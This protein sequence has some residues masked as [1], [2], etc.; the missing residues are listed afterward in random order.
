MTVV[1]I[2][3][4]QIINLRILAR[5]AQSLGDNV[6][7]L[8]FDDPQRALDSF[9]TEPPDLIVTDFVMPI[10]DG[11]AFI[12]RCRRHQATIDTPIIVVTAY[13]DRDFRYRALDTGASD[14]LLS[15]VD[16]REFCIRVRNLLS[17]RRHQLAERGRADALEGELE[18]ALHRHAEAMRRK[19]EQL[20]RVVNTVPA[21]ISATD[22][23]GTI[24]L[25]NS[26]HQAYG[27]AEAPASAGLTMSDLFGADYGL[28]HRKLDAEI[29]AGGEAPGAFEEQVEDAGGEPRVLLTTKA[30]LTGAN[31]AAEGVVTVS[32]D[33]TDRKQQEQAVAESEERFRS[34][35][36]GSV[37]G[38]LIERDG[39][40]LFANRTLARLFGHTGE[41]DILAMDRIDGLF[42]LDEHERIRQIRETTMAGDTHG[43]LKEFAG[44][45]KTGEPIWLQAQAQRVSWKGKNALQLTVADVTLR[46]A[47][48]LQLQKQANFDALT[49]LPN[50]LLMMDRLRGAILSAA[51]H[52]HRGAV[53]FIDLDHFK[54]INDTLGHAT[55]DALLKEAADRLTHCVR[56][57]DTVSRIGGD[58]FT[59]ILPNIDSAASAEPVVQKI[60]QTFSQPFLLSDLE[61]VVSA[62]IGITIFP[63]GGS[64]PE[65]LM[66]NADVAMYRSKERG[67]NTFE[68]FTESLSIRASE[69]IRMETS[70]RHALARNELSVRF[71]PIFDVRSKR[72]AGAEAQLHWH[73]PEMGPVPP[74][75]FM[76][77]AEETGLIVPIRAWSLDEACRQWSR[78][79]G[80]GL[81]LGRLVVNISAGHKRVGSLLENVKTILDGYA[82]DG[83]WLELEISERSLLRNGD[84]AA[85]NLYA[86]D[87]FGVQIAVDEF[88]AEAASVTQLRDITADEIRISGAFFSAALADN[89]HARIIQAIV[90]MAHSLGIRVVANGVDSE[91]HL[92]LARSSGCDFAQGL[93]LGS[94]LPAEAY[95]R[96]ASQQ[97]AFD[98]RAV[99]AESAAAGGLPRAP[100]HDAS[101]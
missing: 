60:L 34:L 5:F 19:E 25:L 16:G 64:D 45:K 94:P 13:E 70:L 92:M 6:K 38:I 99:A 46:K 71:Q 97:D 84:G 85:G 75:R 61:A 73:N 56:G 7:V 31:A 21:L 74:E 63:D 29:L 69:E 20:R 90:T 65:T 91:P 15:P 62:S 30:P 8:T 51:R 53:L 17:L 28:R 98:H 36:E 87:G 42:P 14:F 12:G 59:V 22:R 4:D 68:Y 1:Y 89:K 33:I 52:K 50:R 24:C 83:E 66:K 26:R 76:A 72:L 57:E 43:E 81:T 54:K 55:G 9:A 58:E 78:W 67:R 10:M 49:G 35:V 27:A 48:E 39:K 82:L 18:S 88:G 79:R 96:W 32:L 95:A 80:A 77:C 23:N 37:L 47:Y 101:C 11:E 93:Y 40:P 3:D 2:V 86:L 100:V 41:A 44:V